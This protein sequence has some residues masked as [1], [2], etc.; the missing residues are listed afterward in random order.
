M[1]LRNLQTEYVD[2]FQ[3]QVEFH[4]LNRIDAIFDVVDRLIEEG[5]VRHTG[6]STNYPARLQSIVGRDS[7]QSAQFDLNVFQDSPD[8]LEVCEAANLTAIARLPLAMGFL[9]GKFTAGT[10]L[11]PDDVRASRVSSNEARLRGETNQNRFWLRFFENGGAGNSDWIDRLSEIK[12]VLT[13]DGK[14]SLAQG[15]LRWI[16]ARYPKTVVIPGART[17][18]QF[19][20]NFGAV[21]H[22]PLSETDMAEIENILRRD[23]YPADLYLRPHRPAA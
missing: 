7:V 4:T 8:M 2:I 15:A 6:W 12:T 18:D 11:S 1:T 9:T 5:K 16:F 17:V 14:T 22:G 23:D 10:S 13:E 19:K 20:E 21:E 3:L